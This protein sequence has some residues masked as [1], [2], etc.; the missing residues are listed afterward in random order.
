MMFSLIILTVIATT[1]VYLYSKAHLLSDIDAKLLKWANYA[2]ITLPADYH[3]KITDKNSVSSEDYYEIVSKNSLRCR[4]MGLQYLWSVLVINPQKIVFTTST[5]PSKD[6]SKQD[7]ARFFDVHSDPDAY[8][9]AIREMKP[10]FST[11]KNEWGYGRMV[12]VP[13]QDSQG[14][15]FIFGASVDI[16]EIISAQKKIFM[17]TLFSCLIFILFGL[18]YSIFISRIISKPIVKLNAMGS[19]ISEGRYDEKI[20]LKGATELENLSS[21]INAMSRK[22]KEDMKELKNR[23]TEG[24]QYKRMLDYS[25]DGIYK[26]DLNGKIL[27]LNK[28]MLR[29]LD[30]NCEPEDLIGKEIKDAMIYINE[31]GTLR[32]QLL[33]KGELHDYEYQFKT[34]KGV[35][36]WILLNA[37]LVTEQ[38]TNERI[39]EAHAQ[40]ITEPKKLLEERESSLEF[41]KLVNESENITEMI[42][43]TVTY[44]QKETTCE[45]IGVRLKKNEDFPYFEY[46]GFSDE[47]I[48]LE[49]S[50]CS[51]NA[52]GEILRDASG[53][54]VLECM[55]GNIISGRF[56]PSKPFFTEFGSFWANSTTRLLS[57]TTE[58]DRQ[59]KTR[60]RCN[61]EGYES[62][63]LIPLFSSS[64]R[65]GLIQIND[66]RKDMFSLEKIT[67][68]E[69]LSQYLS[70]AISKFK[71]EEKLEEYN[72][73]LEETISQRTE[74]LKISQERLL[75]AE[76]VSHVG[77]FEVNLETRETFCSDELKKI[78]GIQLSDSNITLDSLEG[79][80]FSEDRS[81]AMNLIKQAINSENPVEGEWRI[82]L[83]DGTLR[84]I[85]GRF[86]T[87]QND[88]G[89]PYILTGVHID[90]TDHKEAEVRFMNSQ[91]QLKTAEK[92]AALGKM[93]GMV[94]HELRN[95]MASIN[96]A[97]YS[98]KMEIN[99][100]T[101][102]KKT[103]KYIRIIDDEIAASN[104]IISNILTYGKTT[105]AKLRNV[106]L[107]EL[108]DGI[109]NISKIYSNITLECAFNP[110]LIE[111]VADPVLM[112][113]LFGNLI[114]NSMEAMPEG[115]ILSISALINNLDL[116]IRIKDT[117]SGIKEDLLPKVFD[118]GF[119]TKSNG[120]GIGLAVCD[121]IVNA[122]HGRI[123]VKSEI[124][125]GTEFIITLPIN[126]K[127]DLSYDGK[128]DTI[129]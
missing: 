108:I 29:I 72:A 122:H 93:A 66:H 65:Y 77:T 88:S 123:E 116:E 107:K 127:R 78:Y 48:H 10:V 61:G 81:K 70:I 17:I 125:K 76:Q 46:R 39:I 90:I 56:D 25:G 5:S 35:T 98:L 89:R 50:L 18:V 124:N 73:R 71:S 111:F 28:G 126:N 79:C 15:I 115:G 4:E 20:V 101:K 36:R 34:L 30:L 58:A 11:F 62:V 1:V 16:N 87:I 117:G 3:D 31:I 85:L 24:K 113:H 44:I 119:S 80:I 7:Y 104:H 86:Q 67:F 54:P 96:S 121:A 95:T 52:E 13:E 128:K 40:D 57:T 60:N 75:L 120:I 110:E 14:R 2:R 19:Y 83:P 69:H 32:K 112:E 42:K 68:W 129:G 114:S 82:S 41:L 94:A 106:N 27:S 8:R 26:Y 47:F 64:E 49:N 103:I 9:E 74:Q 97:A 6:M 100:K 102:E 109:I 53:N 118:L 51:C 38:N 22:I 21:V 12:L 45:A 84:W 92:F 43:A 59:S 91:N 23:E 33:E 99:E 55:C 63:A 105:E 37:L